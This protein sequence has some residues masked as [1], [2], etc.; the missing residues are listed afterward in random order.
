[1]RWDVRGYDGDGRADGGE[2][3]VLAVLVV[4]NLVEAVGACGRGLS[5][6]EGWPW[7]AVA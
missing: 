6:G 3:G 4:V 7:L 5:A 2:C 1:M